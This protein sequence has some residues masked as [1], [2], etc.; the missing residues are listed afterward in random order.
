MQT[1]TP[2][3]TL[4]RYRS[5]LRLL[6]R[7]QLHRRLKTKLDESDIV[8]MTMLYAHENRDQFRGQSEREL[9][10]WLRRILTSTVIDQVRRFGH[11][12]RD[13]ELER[14]LQ[15]ELDRST[16]RLTQW[17]AMERPSPSQLMIKDEQIS[18]LCVAIESLPE[19][20]RSAIILQRLYGFSI[21]QIAEEMGK[22]ESA[23]GGLLRRA[24]RGLRDQLGPP[25]S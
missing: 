20:Q 3:P 10:A 15:L 17:L 12:K 18:E 13:V 24:M 14:S 1:P 22:S 4:N 9:L 21:D 7:H 16:N 19:Q 2:T 11:G 6:A 8:Q 5:Y 25:T 23:V